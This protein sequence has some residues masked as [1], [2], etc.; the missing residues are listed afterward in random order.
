MAS[1]YL[2][3]PRSAIVPFVF[4]NKY[5]FYIFIVIFFFQLFFLN[6]PTLIEL[7]KNFKLLPHFGYSSTFWNY[8]QLH[9]CFATLQL[10]MVYSPNK[11]YT[12]PR[13]HLQLQQSQ[14]FSTIQS[15]LHLPDITY[16][17]RFLIISGHWII[18]VGLDFI[19]SAFPFSLWAFCFCTRKQ[20]YIP[21][22]V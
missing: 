13:L 9:Y 11:R 17:F 14:T 20:F 18:D 2:D 7:N 1:E 12:L 21:P 16:E 10:E 3:I 4:L 22:I 19:I 8:V 6:S 5:S 15:H